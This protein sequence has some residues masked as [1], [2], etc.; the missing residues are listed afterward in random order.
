MGDF[1]N[2]FSTLATIIDFGSGTIKAGLSGEEKPSCIFDSIIGTSKLEQVLPNKTPE[3]I[4]GPKKQIRGLYKLQKPITRGILTSCADANLIMKKIYHE[5]KAIN[6]KEIP[7]FIAEPPFTPIKQKKDLTELLFENYDTPNIFF[8]TQSV[9]SLYSFGKTDGIIIESGEDITQ[10]APV[11]KGYKLDYAVQKINFGGSDVTDSLKSLL[12]HCGLDLASESDDFLV[13]EIKEH[14]CCIENEGEKFEEVIEYD[15]PD[16]EV[17]RIGKE[18]FEACEVFFEKSKSGSNFKG[19]HNFLNS[20]LEKL[21]QDLQKYL[22]NSI[23][24]SGGNSMMNGFV[25]RLSEEMDN[26]VGDRFKCNITAVNTDRS[27]LAWQGASF[28]TN[29]NSFP[30]LWISK[31]DWEEEG[32]QIFY[33]KHF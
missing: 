21:D 14:V 31:K 29:I 26:K 28:I 18:R 27:L 19:M 3:K 22:Y 7:I 20:S 24:I 13:R 30:K 1:K 5:L 25:E 10:I 4:V 12:R 17:V 33:K 32:E 6:N 23:Y 8:G 2:I 15:L 11:Y 9:L 16:G